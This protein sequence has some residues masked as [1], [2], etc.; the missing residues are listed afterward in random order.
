MTFLHRW[1]SIFRLFPVCGSF[2][3]QASFCLH[4]ENTDKNWLEDEGNTVQ[5][6]R[7]YLNMLI[8][9]SRDFISRGDTTRVLAQNG[10]GATT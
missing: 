10:L 2:P 3:F 8:Q 9:L 6:R 1:S 7:N 5:G 4:S